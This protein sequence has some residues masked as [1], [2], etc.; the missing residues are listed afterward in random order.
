[1]EKKQMS[2]ANF[3]G[4]AARTIK[5][6]SKKRR[7]AKSAANDCYGQELLNPHISWRFKVIVLLVF[8]VLIYPGVGLLC[9]HTGSSF[10]SLKVLY[11]SS[12]S[13]I[14]F[15]LIF[16]INI[17]DKIFPDDDLSSENL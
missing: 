13:A 14:V 10:F 12:G 9:Q 6:L 4:E 8:F 2:N 17:I 11:M 15:W 5:R 3:S 16:V 1:M 7:A